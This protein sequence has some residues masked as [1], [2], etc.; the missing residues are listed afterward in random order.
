MVGREVS[1]FK[2]VYLQKKIDNLRNYT[3]EFK[4]AIDQCRPV[5]LASEAMSI[6][7]LTKFLESESKYLTRR[8]GEEID[9]LK[10]EYAL[11]FQR[12]AIGKA[13]ECKPKAKT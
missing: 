12:L 3:K 9:N 5:G 10:R 8:Q 13:C 11:Q 1:E 6:G 2:E 7:I 4:E